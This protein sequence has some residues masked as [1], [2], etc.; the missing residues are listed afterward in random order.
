MHKRPGIVSD[1]R[2]FDHAIPQHSL[3]NPARLRRLYTRLAAEPYLGRVQCFRPREAS[4][5]DIE[6][7]HSSFYQEQLREHVNV[8]DPFSYDR[9]T[10]LMEQSLYTAALA[11]GGCLELADRIVAGEIDYG[12]ALVRPPGHHAEPGRGMGFCLYN[13]VAITAQYLRRVYGMQRILIL[14]FDVHH[15][16]GTQ[17]VF[18]ETD[19]VLFCSIHQEKLFPFTGKPQEV[20]IGKGYGYTLNLPVHQQFG[21]AEYLFLLNRV[22]GNVVEQYLPQIILVSAGYDG[23]EDDSISRTLLSTHWFFVVTELL[24]FFA[25]EV[26]DDR[27]LFIL[28]GG[29]NPVSLEA[30]VLATVDSL[31]TPCGKRPGVA[32]S[33]R[34]AKILAHHPV[35]QFWTL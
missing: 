29:Y 32:Y 4:A 22:L 14:D 9:D 7:V 19:Q 23:H 16:N 27:V 2:F 1:Q 3:E 5:E 15:G 34:A 20:G 28:E 13:N 33:Q 31:L 11:A 35:H 21:D 24:K 30:S 8:Q 25:H 6:A 17:A 18:N 26:C 12:F 10:Y